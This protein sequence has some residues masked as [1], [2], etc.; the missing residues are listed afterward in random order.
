[1]RY[2]GVKDVVWLVIVLIIIFVALRYLGI[3]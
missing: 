1:M 2:M 3:V